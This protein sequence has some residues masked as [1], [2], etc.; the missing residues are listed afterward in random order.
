MNEDIGGILEAA[1]FD[2]NRYMMGL[3]ASQFSYDDPNVTATFKITDGWLKI[4]PVD[5]TPTTDFTFTKAWCGI[6]NQL[7]DTWPSDI[8]DISISLYNSKIEKVGDFTL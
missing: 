3:E 8:S 6:D 4:D 1:E 7:M 2:D 5:H